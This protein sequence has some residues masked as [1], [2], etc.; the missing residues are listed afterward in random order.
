MPKNDSTLQ[1][2]ADRALPTVVVDQPIIPNIPFVGI[3]DRAASR[4]CAQ[5]LKTL[6][7]KRFAIVSLRLGT[8]GYR[9]FV[10]PERLKN[11]CFELSRRRIEGYLDVVGRNGSNSFAKIWECPRSEAAPSDKRPKRH[12]VPQKAERMLPGQMQVL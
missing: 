10:E 8:D 12:C 4:A 7:H 2:V 9:G 1:M 11:A 6:G 3:N 5:H